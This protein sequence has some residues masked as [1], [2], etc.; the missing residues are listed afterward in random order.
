[1]S[2]SN[3]NFSD[4][5]LELAAVTGEKRK[6]NE[7]SPKSETKRREAECVVRP[8][9]STFY[10]S[11]CPRSSSMNTTSDSGCEKDD[12]EENPYPLD[13]KY[14]DEYDRQRYTVIFLALPLEYN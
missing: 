5:F 1:M 4:N 10:K 3:G 12:V 6:R 14:I 13:G 9:P 7:G 11:I 8:C 2:D